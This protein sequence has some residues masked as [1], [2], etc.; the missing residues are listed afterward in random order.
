MVTRSTARGGRAAPQQLNFQTSEG[1][2]RIFSLSSA[3]QQAQLRV[4][5]KARRSAFVT[6]APRGAS[7]Q[8]AGPGAGRG[9]GGRVAGG[10]RG[11][12][13]TTGCSGVHGGDTQPT[14]LNQHYLTVASF[15]CGRL[16]DSQY[17]TGP[18]VDG[19]RTSSGTTATGSCCAWKLFILRQAFLRGRH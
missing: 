18:A 4:M 6:A 17:R 13:A 2:V 19:S 5:R 1:P 10:Q 7:A 11:H 12:G 9:G 16:K 3:D 15:G 8:V 14:S